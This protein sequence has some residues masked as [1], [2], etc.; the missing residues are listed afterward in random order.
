[1][2]AAAPLAA[3]GASKLAKRAIGNGGTRSGRP[4]RRP[5]RA[6]RTPSASRA[7][8]R[9][10]KEAGKGLLPGGG[11]SSSGGKAGVGK[12]RRM[13]VQ[14]SVD[15]AVPLQT[16]TTSGLSSSARLHAPGHQRLPGGRDHRRLPAKIWG[17]SKGSG[18]ILDQRP[19]E[20]DQV[21]EVNEGHPHR[22]GVVPRARAQAHPYRAHARRR[23][24]L[25]DREG[26]ARDA[27]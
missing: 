11:G 23:P 16:P 27:P 19:D 22:R 20:P 8:R 9:L 1:M 25:P 3:K 14:Q 13:P 18:E 24:R 6:P 26:G 21:G 12:G 10:A 15:V 17:V 5:P 4:E 2:A 7:A